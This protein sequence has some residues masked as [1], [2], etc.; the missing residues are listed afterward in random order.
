M[1][2]VSKWWGQRKSQ[3]STWAGLHFL[4]GLGGVLLAGAGNTTPEILDT[5]S[6][7]AQ[8]AADAASMGMNPVPVFLMGLT[9]LFMVASDTRTPA[10]TPQP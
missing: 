10:A 5:A 9:S 1:S 7:A 6:Q 2:T 3:A 8:Q 4:A